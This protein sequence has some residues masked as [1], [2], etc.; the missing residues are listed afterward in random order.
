MQEQNFQQSIL[1]WYD[2][3]GRTDL[4]WQK[5]INPYKVWVSEIMLQQTQVN[6][7]IPYYD[8]FM[9][10]FPDLDSLADA[11]LDTVLQHWAGL[12]YYARARNLHKSAQMMQQWGYFPDTLEALVSLPGIGLST[13]GA[14][15]SIAFKQSQ[16]ILDG[17]VKRVLAR[18]HAISGWTGDTKVLQELWRLSALYT[19]Q[20]RAD[21]YTQAIMDLG[22]TL[23]TRSKP[24]CQA[25]PIQIDCLARIEAKT[26]QLPMPK[27]RKPL[28]VK[29]CYFLIAFQ[30][31][32]EVLLMHRPASGIW[33]GLWS[34]PE[35]SSRADADAWCALHHLVIIEQSIASM[36]R[37]SFT[38]FHLDYTPLLIKVNNLNNNVME[39]NTGIWYKT[40][41]IK[42][43][44]LP[45]PISR[46]LHYYCHT[47]E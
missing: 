21:A 1:N 18:F 17:N 14:I 45:A 4:P 22:A 29:Q 7:V 31:N 42:Q 32:S 9:A 38:H 23:C 27:P 13:A 15:L 43:L 39:A 36:Q 11:P 19:P 20:K 12:G 41:D 34:L 8:K 35:F 37:H 44:A 47:A 33:G 28:P 10:R 25:C 2:Q 30:Q 3:F 6:T 40:A 26:T 24:R 46:L 5:A 16:P